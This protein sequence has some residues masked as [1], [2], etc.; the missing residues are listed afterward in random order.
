MV[1]LR[2]KF[3]AETCQKIGAAF[4]AAEEY[5]GT[6]LPADPLGF[7]VC[8]DL[9]MYSDQHSDVTNTPANGTG[10]QRYKSVSEVRG[11]PC[12]LATHVP[13]PVLGPRSAPRL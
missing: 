2:L 6:A 3:T 9:G 7:D 11:Y 4:K 12:H 8:L 10:R 1:M 5:R 13:L